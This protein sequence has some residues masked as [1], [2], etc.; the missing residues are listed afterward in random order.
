MTTHF[1]RLITGGISKQLVTIHK[2]F[3]AIQTT[4]KRSP[5]SFKAQKRY[6]AIHATISFVDA[7]SRLEVLSVILIKCNTNSK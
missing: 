3:Q 1:K 5:V 2:R 7:S 4:Q 6:E